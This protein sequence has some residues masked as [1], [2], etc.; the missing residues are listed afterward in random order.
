MSK[1]QKTTAK[2]LEFKNWGFGSDNNLDE[3]YKE[4]ALEGSTPSILVSFRT[5]TISNN[6]TGY[7]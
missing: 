6:G 4:G 2:Y 3:E 5:S 7:S 1:L